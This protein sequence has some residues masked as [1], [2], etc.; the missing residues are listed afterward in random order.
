MRGRMLSWIVTMVGFGAVLLLKA[1]NFHSDCGSADATPTSIEVIIERKRKLEEDCVSRMTTVVET[2]MLNLVFLKSSFTTCWRLHD[3]CEHGRSD[4]HL[5]MRI[6]GLGAL[7]VSDFN[8]S[9][10]LT[11]CGYKP[12]I[13]CDWSCYNVTTSQ[14]VSPRENSYALSRPFDAFF[15]V[16]ID[17]DN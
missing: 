8:E 14:R 10:M 15:I 4:L 9:S 17:C 16:K 6:E 3:G 12:S 13:I 2:S 1:F 7:G 5:Y 11:E